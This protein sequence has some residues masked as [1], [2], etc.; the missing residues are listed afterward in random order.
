MP[1]IPLTRGQFAIVDE[2]DFEWLNAFKWHAHLNSKT[3]LFVPCRHGSR[4]EGGSQT[5]PIYRDI[6]GI[7]DGLSPDHINRNT[8]DNR[9]VNLRWA[10]VQQN[11]FN[12]RHR[13][14]ATGFRGVFKNSDGRFTARIIISIGVKKSIGTFKTAVEAAR[15]WNEAAQNQYGAFAVL[16]SIQ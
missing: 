12:R 2:D 1:L 14:N 3:G 10:T 5:V 15:A 11:C 6:M 9:R 8:L 7:K 13:K 16:N 4:S